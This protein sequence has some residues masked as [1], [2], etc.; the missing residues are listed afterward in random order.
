MVARM[1]L[2]ILD[3]KFGHALLDEATQFTSLRDTREVA[4]HIGHEAGY[5]CLAE[6][7]GHH[8][9][10]NGFTCTCG[11]SNQTMTVGHLTCNTQC[12]IRAV[13]YVKPSFLVVHTLL[14]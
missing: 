8:L 4:L 10:G 2:R 9:Q 3:A 12:S 5:A 13:G 1:G 6:G 7:L 14:F 11:T